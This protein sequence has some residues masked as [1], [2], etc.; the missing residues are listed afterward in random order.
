VRPYLVFLMFAFDWRFGDCWVGG[1]G[2]Q[3][4]IERGRIGCS[5]ARGPNPRRKP[6]QKIIISAS[7]NGRQRGIFNSSKGIFS[8]E[9]CNF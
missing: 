9:R 1:T 4:G 7:T 6:Q 2:A 8:Q 5:G 3:D